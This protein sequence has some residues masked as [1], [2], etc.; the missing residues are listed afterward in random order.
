MQSKDLFYKQ[1][2]TSLK[3]FKDILSVENNWRKR[4]SILCDILFYGV[5][6]LY[7][8]GYDMESL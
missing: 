6:I 7:N 1:N 3:R 2:D 5:M 8:A 4:E